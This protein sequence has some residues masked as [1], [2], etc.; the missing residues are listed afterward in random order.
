[1]EKVGTERR[2]DYGNEFE[3]NGGDGDGGLQGDGGEGGGLAFMAASW[4]SRERERE[5]R[6]IGPCGCGHGH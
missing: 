2:L 6:W 5:T 1:M 4:N 3:V